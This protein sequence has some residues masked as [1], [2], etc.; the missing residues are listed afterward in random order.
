MSKAREIIHRAKVAIIDL[1]LFKTVNSSPSEIHRQIISTRLFIL[2]FLAATAGLLQYTLLSL[3]VRTVIK[4]QPTIAVYD[5]L[6]ARYSSSLQ[7]P[8]TQ[9]SFQYGSYIRAVPKFHQVCTSFFI[10]Q[11]WIDFVY[12]DDIDTLWPMD[13]RTILSFFWQLIRLN[14]VAAMKMIETALEDFLKSSSVHLTVGTR[15]F[16]NAQSLAAVDKVYQ[17]VITDFAR[18]LKI[19]QG[20]SQVNGYMTGLS[21]NFALTYNGAF[22]MRSV[23]V[24]LGEVYYIIE[25]ERVLCSCYR[26]GSCQIPAGVYMSARTYSSRIHDTTGIEADAWINGIVIDCSP[27]LAVFS[28]TLECFYDQNCLDDIFFAYERYLDIPTLDSFVGSH[29]SPYTSLKDIVDEMFLETIDTQ[30]NF[31]SYYQQCAPT[32]CTY[33]NERRF[34]TLFVVTTVAALIGGLTVALRLIVLPLS[35]SYVYVEKKI[36]LLSPQ[37][38]ENASKLIF[39]ILTFTEKLT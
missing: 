33:T 11:E 14:C 1:N 23:P 8:C 19:L 9:V 37:L 25:N 31:D 24:T 16:V 39:Q 32:Y 6:F 38:Q 28:S 5:E 2:L 26:Q 34:D 22:D 30:V 12:P 36:G 7:C 18:S 29:F 4:E 10:D 21:T 3:H 15:S 35:M 20:I 17:T 27:S 13:I